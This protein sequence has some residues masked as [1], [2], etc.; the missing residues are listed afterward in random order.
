[1]PILCEVSGLLLSDQG[2]P[3]EGQT[4]AIE[5]WGERSGNDDSDF[6]SEITSDS[7]GK[8]VFTVPQGAR[9]A[10]SSEDNHGPA[11]I[12]GIRVV[13]PNSETFNLGNFRDGESE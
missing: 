8:I 10:F 11:S 1:M 9:I 12:N 6:P 5:R 13:I 4:V 2:A 3:A 7:A